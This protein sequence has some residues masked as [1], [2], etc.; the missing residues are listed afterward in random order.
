MDIKYTASQSCLPIVKVG[1]ASGPHNSESNSV[2]EVSIP[3]APWEKDAT[4]KLI[5]PRL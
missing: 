1:V 4:D 5:Y 2:G 3:I